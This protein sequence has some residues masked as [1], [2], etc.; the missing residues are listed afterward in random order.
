MYF[1]KFQIVSGKNYKVTVGRGG[2]GDLVKQVL[3]SAQK[4][5]DSVFGDHIAVGGGGG[6]VSGFNPT[7]GGSGG[8]CRHNS[9]ST[10]GGTPGS[11]IEGQGHAGGA[12]A[13]GH[14]AS[15]GGGAGLGI[16]K[17]VG[18][19]QSYWNTG[20]GAWKTNINNWNCYHY[21]GGGGGG[22][23]ESGRN[24]DGFGGRRW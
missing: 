9:A 11:G 24:S 4:G 23:N 14:Q 8:G 13:N 12:S 2:Y 22:G 16:Q 18:T 1:E 6:G 21:G 19:Q 15:G 7:S 17:L 20:E 3:Q 10:N 5:Y